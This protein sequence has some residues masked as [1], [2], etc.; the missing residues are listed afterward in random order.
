MVRDSKSSEI[1]RLENSELSSRLRRQRLGHG[2]DGVFP[3]MGVSD[4][5][6]QRAGRIGAVHRQAGSDNRRPPVAT[7]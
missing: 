2:H 1:G 3:V 7:T 5:D 4:R 6:R